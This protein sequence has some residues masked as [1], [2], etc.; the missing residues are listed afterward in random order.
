MATGAAYQEY[1]SYRAGERDTTVPV[2][3]TVDFS[4]PLTLAMTNIAKT[5]KAL[6]DV[7]TTTNNLGAALASSVAV[8]NQ[9]VTEDKAVAQTLV[10]TKQ[11]AQQTVASITQQFPQITTTDNQRNWQIFQATLRGKGFPQSL[12]N[13]SSSFF[14]AMN[15]DGITDADT[16][17][18]LYLDAKDYTTK[19][20]QTI[21]SPFYDAYGKFNEGLKV[22]YDSATLFNTIEGYR[23]IADKYSWNSKFIADSS[24]ANYL[25]N[26]IDV[27]TLDERAN[28]ARLKAASADPVYTKALQAQ[29]YISSSQDLQDFFLDPTVGTQVMDQRRNTAAVT[30]EFFRQQQQE[31][32]LKFH[33]DFLAQLGAKYT[34]MGYTESEAANLAQKSYSTIA[35]ELN[36]MT[37]LSG[38]YSG[39]QALTAEQAQTQLEQEQFQGLA[40]QQRALLGGMESQA[41]QGMAGLSGTS[42]YLRKTSLS[43][44]PIGQL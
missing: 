10:T 36:P 5:Q 2:V 1:Q 17:I 12:I 37:K 18:S 22:P 9:M 21:R 7:V 26:G 13:A 31:K 29:G 3:P 32:A 43:K 35:T 16:Q 20:G 14:N 15:N 11:Q 8:A 39:N 33:Q 34:S 40:S 30:A 24:I 23:N 4:D 42:A 28:A 38:I 6:A 19:N 25:K 27:K 41:F 44:S